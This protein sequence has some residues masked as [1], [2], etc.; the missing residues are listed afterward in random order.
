MVFLLFVTMFSV[1]GCTRQK[2]QV[3]LMTKLESG[4]IVG[5]SEVNAAR[6][7]LEDNDID[8]IEVTPFDD[9]WDP[10]KALQA[11]ADIRSRGINI[12]VT[13]HVSTCA[14]ALAEPVNRDGVL[15]LVTG[16]TTDRLTGQDDFIIRNVQDVS[17]EQKNIGRWMR[18]KAYAGLLVVRDTDNSAYTEPALKYFSE[19]YGQQPPVVEVSM[20][21]LNM[22][23]LKARMAAQ[24]FASLYLLIGAY[25]SNAGSIAQ[26]ARTIRPDVPIV[27]TPWMKTPTLLETAGNSLTGS[28]MPS[29][30]PPKGGNAAVDEYVAH[31]HKKFGY[32]P[33]FISLNVYSA[34]DILNQAIAAGHRDPQAIREYI[35]KKGAF[36][37]RFGEIRFDRYGD[38]AGDLYYIENIAG[39]SDALHSHASV[40]SGSSHA[41]RG[42]RVCL[43]DAVYP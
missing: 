15:T 2:I 8:Y 25:R 21:N 29:H 30:Y 6:L 16:A 37:T 10:A 43:S 11:Y 24:P 1:A 38:A 33:T 3:A 41:D 34:F 31:F 9:A 19:A 23:E 22:N 14:V 20:N 12:L 36:K 27:Y 7:F 26:L 28:I 32:A 13:S 40:C 35:L 4:S 17:Q 42:G 39:N 18:G 5:S